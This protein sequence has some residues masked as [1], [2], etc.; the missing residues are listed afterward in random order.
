MGDSYGRLS[1]ALTESKVQVADKINTT[2]VRIR[3]RQNLC[4]ECGIV[5]VGRVSQDM[6]LGCQAVALD[7]HQRRINSIS[8]GA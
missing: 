5:W 7:L 1:E 6:D 3:R 2:A 4:P 8:G